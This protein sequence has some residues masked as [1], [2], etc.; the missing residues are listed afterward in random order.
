[1]EDMKLIN[2]TKSYGELA[3]LKDVSIDICNGEIVSFVGRSGC[4]KTTLLKIMA[5]ITRQDSGEV[6]GDRQANGAGNV[7]FVFQDP[8]LASWR[9]VAGNIAL[10]LE[11]RKVRKPER[12]IIVDD[13]LKLVDLI[14]FGNYLPSQL[15]GGMQ[16]RTAIARALAT[17]PKLLLMD[18]PFSKLDELTRRSLNEQLLRIW[19]SLAITVVFITHSIDEAIYLSKRVVVLSDRPA[20]VKDVFE[21]DIPYPRNN[22]MRYMPNFAKLSMQIENAIKS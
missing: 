21:I 22:H 17:N 20:Y 12:E 11:I 13:V 15:S 9:S 18:E 8:T 1:M 2:I 14:D 10:P 19:D 7:G 3:V 6:I 4:G 5:G 16:Q